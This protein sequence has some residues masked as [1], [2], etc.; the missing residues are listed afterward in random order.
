[1]L[2]TRSF[3]AVSLMLVLILLAACQQESDHLLLPAKTQ[4]DELNDW[5]ASELDA[6]ECPKDHPGYIASGETRGRILTHK[7][8]LEELGVSV[9]WNCKIHAFEPVPKNQSV[10]PVCGCKQ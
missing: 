1:M 5:D 10:L 8:N 2:K 6:I 7:E 9:R 4:L 3:T